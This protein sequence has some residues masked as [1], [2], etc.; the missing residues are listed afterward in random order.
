MSENLHIKWVVAHEPIDLFLRSAKKFKEII[1]DLSNGKIDVEVLTK[2]DWRQKYNISE[3]VG[4]MKSLQNNEI[5]MGQYQTTFLGVLDKN[6][7]VFDMPFLFKDHDH[8]DRVLNGKIGNN[9]LKLLG[10]ENS[11]MGLA[12]TYSGGFRI[13][14][15][16][17]PVTKLEQ[18]QGKNI[19]C[20]PS[21]VLSEIFKT[22]GANVINDLSWGTSD[23]FDN[24]NVSG[25]DVNS[26]ETTFVR[27]SKVKDKFPYIT[28]SKHSL[29]L[30][31]I[32][33][34]KDF[35]NSLSEEYQEIFNKAAKEAAMIER[36]QT[37]EDS[38][39]FKKNYK[40]LCSGLYEF[41]EEDIE[42]FKS[43]TKTLYSSDFA[44]QA[45]TPGLLKK[46]QNA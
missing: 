18:L 24:I 16:K 44:K 29:F 11:I 3:D 34:N 31:T 10:K 32:V 9:L 41:S 23:E 35:Y 22:V 36:K 43:A 45:F 4:L 12:F 5:Q 46:I 14:I 26:S 20:V 2:N 40:E 21:P 15:N 8:V 37:I 27:Y 6:F 19:S 33:I 30:T 25:D 17:E 42:K 39:N 7:N 1:S 13:M 28:D 38:K